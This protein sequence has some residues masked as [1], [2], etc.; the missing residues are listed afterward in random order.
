MAE[1]GG[2]N[3]TLRLV[4]VSGHLMA[5]AHKGWEFEDGTAAFFHSAPDKQS[6]GVL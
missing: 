2:A 3:L 5:Q 1:D 4:E 6:T